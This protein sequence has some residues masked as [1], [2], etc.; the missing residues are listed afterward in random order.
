MKSREYVF[1]Y[2]YR[3][4][5]KKRTNKNNEMSANTQTCWSKMK[6]AFKTKRENLVISVKVHQKS[7]CVSSFMNTIND[8]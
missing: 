6:L 4:I 8:R 1:P 3:K 7:N 2:L 5:K